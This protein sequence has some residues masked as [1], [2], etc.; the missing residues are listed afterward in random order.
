MRKVLVALGVLPL[1]AGLATSGLAQTVDTPPPDPMGGYALGKTSDLANIPLTER[2]F[3]FRHMEELDPYPVHLLRHGDA[4]RPLPEGPQIDVNAEIF[5]HRETIDSFMQ[6]YHTAA[7]LVIKDGKIRAERYRY[8]NTAHSKV[9]IQSITKSVVSTALAAALQDGR[10]HSV[11]DQIVQYVPELKGS[12]YDGVTIQD[13][14]NMSSGVDRADTYDQADPKMDAANAAYFSSDPQ[15]VF[16]ARPGD[17]P[18]GGNA[19]RR[20]YLEED[21]DAGG[22][23]GRCLH[24]HHRRRSGSGPWRA[25][26]DAPRHGPLR[27]VRDGQGRRQREE[28][29]AAGLVRCDLARR[30]RSQ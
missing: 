25:E 23:G 17:D 8:G 14:L 18:G 9:V 12:A 11:S 4:L 21:L 7:L 27:P 15:A 3:M 19:A 20:L 28:H 6:R 16:R 29:R 22:H 5:G 13:A 10:I 1:L 2:P 30:H 24:A 26:R